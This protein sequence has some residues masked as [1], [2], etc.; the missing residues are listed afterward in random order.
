M[1]VLLL[2]SVPPTIDGVRSSRWRFFKVIEGE[3][4][5]QT[6]FIAK[7]EKW[8]IFK[9]NSRETAVNDLYVP[10]CMYKISK[11]VITYI[12]VDYSYKLTETIIYT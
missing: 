9:W 7:E 4:V 3:H 6:Q 2:S 1:P 8:P 5:S 11:Y 12:D 10:E